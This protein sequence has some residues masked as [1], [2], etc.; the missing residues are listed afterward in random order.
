MINLPSGEGALPPDDE[1]APD[2]FIGDDGAEASKTPYIGEE[3]RMHLLME[4]MAKKEEPGVVPPRSE[5]E[6]TGE[7]LGLDPLVVEE[8]RM[9][10]GLIS[11]TAVDSHGN[12]REGGLTG[13]IVSWEKV[14]E[15]VGKGRMEEIKA[16]I[17]EFAKRKR[18]AFDAKM[19]AMRKEARKRDSGVG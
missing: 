16:W 7:G 15:R 13:R 9:L 6:M 17:S 12:L 18:E 1:D 3:Y 2:E 5:R 11:G 10:R 14:E 8:N 19:E 4:K